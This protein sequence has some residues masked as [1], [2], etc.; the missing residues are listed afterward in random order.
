MK[1]QVVFDAAHPGFRTWSFASFGLIVVFF[2][3]IF[4]IYPGLIRG[5]S[6][7]SKRLLALFMIAAAIL[8]TS[9]S[10]STTQKQVLRLSSALRENRCGIAE[11]RVE[12]FQAESDFP[13]KRPESFDVGNC[14]FFYDEGV[15]TGAFNQPRTWGGPI[16]EGEQVRI[17]YLGNDIARLEVAAATEPPQ[18]SPSPAATPG[19]APT[20][21]PDGDATLK[22]QKDVTTQYGSVAEPAGTRVHLLDEREGKWTVECNAGRLEV[23][24]QDLIPA[25]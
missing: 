6:R 8:W 25:E 5:K 7:L 9:V 2:G 21:H 13:K 23:S 20:L 17:H 1:Y 4:F 10:F 15:V 22:K 19:P 12:H 24:P 3:I 16:Y 11:G 18:A 14:H